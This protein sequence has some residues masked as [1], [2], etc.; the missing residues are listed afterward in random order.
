MKSI[1]ICKV[2]DFTA[3][4]WL[5][6]GGSAEDARLIAEVYT[7]NT[8]RCM[9]HHDIHNLASRIEGIRSGMIDPKAEITLLS[10]FGGMESWD[11][12]SGAGEVLASHIMNRACDLASVHGIGFAAV[13][14]SN[15]YLSSM[16]Y[17]RYA[18][19]RGYVGFI[20]AKAAPA[21]GMPGQKRNLIGQ[22]P[23]GYAFPT[24][25]DPV[26]LD[27][28]LAYIAHEP[29]KLLADAGGTVPA[30]YGVDAAGKPAETAEDLLAGIKYP[31]GEHKG[32]GLALLEELL[33]GVFS[34]GAI[35][36]EG[37][38][39]KPYKGMTHTAV[40]IRT[41][42]LMDRET[43]EKRADELV[44]RLRA[45]GENV[46]VPGDGSRVKMREAEEKGTL[47]IEEELAE[48]LNG[49]A[50]HAPHGFRGTLL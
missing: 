42:A 6:W 37:E 35:L 50:E 29:L 18:A 19:E 11:G 44:S 5:A 48:K 12:H 41:D 8:K 26:T 7:E 3:A 15:H 34:S 10:S 13:R 16:P 38:D 4:L 43:Y 9:G 23:V 46:H 25:G 45:R 28:C 36:D 14:N 1:P 20:M 2:H 22:A 30:H 31:I 24:G 33:T 32:F 40:A 47:E 21:M 17:V 49:L 39:E 27:M